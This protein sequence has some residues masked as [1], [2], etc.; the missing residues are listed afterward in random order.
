MKT[1]KTKKIKPNYFYYNGNHYSHEGREYFTWRTGAGIR[2]VIKKIA[3]D[4]AYGFYKESKR[5]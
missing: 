5:K 4:E 3:F 1:T 2:H